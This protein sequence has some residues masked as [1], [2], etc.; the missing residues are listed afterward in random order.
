[1]EGIGLKS[2]HG[3]ATTVVL[4]HREGL[5]DSHL[6]YLATTLGIRVLSLA[7]IINVSPAIPDRM[8]SYN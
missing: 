8:V 6:S 3:S 7:D 2:K 1:M 4:M 5:D